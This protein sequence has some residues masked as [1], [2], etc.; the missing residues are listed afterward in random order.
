MM[1]LGPKSNRL[2]PAQSRQAES[3][4]TKVIT[5]RLVDVGPSFSRQR[6]INSRPPISYYV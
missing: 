3:I 6:E 2:S 1:T 4:V 5:E